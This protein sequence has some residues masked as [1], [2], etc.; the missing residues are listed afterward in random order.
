MLKDN[1]GKYYF[2]GNYNC[3]ETLIRAANDYYDLGLHDRDMI[4]YGVFGAGIQTGNTCGAVI[5]AAAVL[6]M[7]YVEKKAHES[8]DIKP[9]TIRLMQEFNKKYGSVL[10]KEIKPQSFDPEVRCKNT[11]EAACDILESVIAEYDSASQG[12][13]P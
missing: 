5:A 3:A 13:T 11:V 8:S 10:C 4:S 2:E 9:V 6:S 1:I 12:Q 7:K